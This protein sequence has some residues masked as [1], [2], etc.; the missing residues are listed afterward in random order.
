MGSTSHEMAREHDDITLQR[1]EGRID[2]PFSF[3]EDADCIENELEEF[4]SYIEAPLLLENKASWMTWARRKWNSCCMPADVPIG[5]WKALDAHQRRR[6][7]HL[8]LNALDLHDT[9]ARTTASHALLY[10]LQ[11]SFGET[12]SEQEQLALIR[13]N[14]RMVFELGGIEDIFV[15]CKRACWRHHL[16]NNVSDQQVPSENSEV[17]AP[18]EK[19]ECLE[20]IN[21]EISTHFSQ[22]YTVIESL[23]GEFALGE[24]LMT[25]SPPLP[26]YFL[27]IIANLREKSISTLR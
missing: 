7:L 23:R 21:V 15:G 22:L 16:L 1:N 14:A 11:G 25:R 9:E 13:E 6:I 8:L 5:A 4:Y 10:H 19:A 12:G 26:I 20:S 27:D 3:Q 2:I 18:K 17:L 24:I